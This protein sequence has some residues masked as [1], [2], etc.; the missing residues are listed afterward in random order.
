MMVPFSQWKGSP[1]DFGKVNRHW[2]RIKYHLNNLLILGKV[3]YLLCYFSS[4]HG[5]FLEFLPSNCS[6]IRQII[7]VPLS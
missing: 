1:E 4:E 7:F 2:N 6:L 3:C 5:M